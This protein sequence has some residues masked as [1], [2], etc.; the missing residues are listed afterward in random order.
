VCSAVRDGDDYLVNGTKTWTTHAHHA[1]WIFL[2]VRTSTAGKPQHGISFLLMDLSSAGV[3]VKPI[4]S[5]SGEHEVNQVFFDNVRVPVANRVGA[6]NEGWSIAKQLLE[7][8]RSGF[9]GPRTRRILSRT[10]RLARADGNLWYSPDFRRR[11]TEISIE[12]DTLEAGE[13]R[14][15][16]EHESLV[17]SV[18]PSLL[19]LA[20][21]ETMQRATELAVFAAGTS[22]AYLFTSVTADAMIDEA[23][24]SMARY[25]NTRAATIYGGSS[26]VQ[27]NILAK[28]ALGL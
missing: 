18:T 15:M 3:T 25:L 1:N 2:L 27:R 19:K 8:E 21:T 26:E 24:I 5:M 4:I 11:F 22:A 20:G 23:S 16:S 28:M 6:E 10:E 12:T 9:Y 7:F 13:L 14:M 17:N